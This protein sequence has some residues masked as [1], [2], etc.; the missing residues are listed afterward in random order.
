MEP[1]IRLPIAKPVLDDLCLKAKDWALMHGVGMR[2][3]S[4]PHP[5][6]MTFASFVLLPSTFPRKE[7]RKAKEA[8]TIMN[9][10]LHKAA[11]DYDFIKQS[12]KTTIEA[13]EFTAGLFNIYET[14]RSEGIAQPVSLGLFRS[15]YLLHA[16]STFIDDARVQQVESNTISSSFGALTTQMFSLHR[17][18]LRELGIENSDYHIPDNTALQGLCSGLVTAWKTYDSPDALI[19]FVVE[20]ITLNICDQRMMEFEIRHQNHHAHVIRKTFRDLAKTAALRDKQLFVDDKEIAVVY[21]RTGYHPSDYHDQQAWDIRLLLER[22]KAIKCPS[23]QYHLVGTKK[24]QQELSCFGMLE[25]FIS[26]TERVLK[27]RELFTG[28]YSLDL[29]KEGDAIVELAVENP[30]KYVLKP[31]REGGGNNFYDEDVRKVLN[32][33]RQSHER[34]AYILMDRIHSP[35][36]RNYM[37][38]PNQP[39]ELCDMVS[40]L[41]I[42]G[43]IIGTEDEIL[44]NNEVG[45]LLRTKQVS[46][47]EGG[48]AAGFSALDSIYLI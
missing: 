34:T 12:L 48:V 40:E 18:I 1:C 7:F 14:V 44:E 41:G 30:Y 16:E 33:I 13:D 11:H 20:E 24:V 28:L 45:H 27:L 26:D 35:S 5:D 19:L 46:E 2:A 23:I 9:E 17:Y 32:R 42:F 8:Q 43:V 6:V 22:S 21:F 10:V 39:P 29:N 4:N 15:D 37:I 38:R 31:Q 25:H 3:P 36:V 47:N